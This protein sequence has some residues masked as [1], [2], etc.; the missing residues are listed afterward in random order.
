[1][2]KTLDKILIIIFFLLMIFVGKIFIDFLGKE[3]LIS[4]DRTVEF[5]EKLNGIIYFGRPSC[6]A[7]EAFEP[8]LKEALKEENA[9]AYYF[10]TD[11]FRTN[12][13]F[14]EEELQAIFK[15]YLV[16]EVPA[17]VE[18]KNGTVI[19]TF[20]GN[21]ISKEKSDYVKKQVS[22][23]I[24]YGK[25]PSKYVEEY[26][27]LLVLFILSTI[28]FL[29]MLYFKKISEHVFFVTLL[30]NICFLVLLILSGSAIIKAMDIYGYSMRYEM[31]IINAA[32][33]I[34]TLLSVVRLHIISDKNLLSSIRNKRKKA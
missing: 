6:P 28:V 3:Y 11:F 33:F 16:S 7:C 1:M 13:L 12:K 9:I 19:N 4:I 22:S 17:L 5:E 14:S 26:N 10:D 18:I 31:S 27:V 29:I 8:I 25:F 34:I 30:F 20:D 21:M 15:K 32:A 23:F 2:K 24:T